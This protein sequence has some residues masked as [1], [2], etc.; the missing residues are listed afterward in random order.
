MFT[1]FLNNHAGII[2]DLMSLYDVLPITDVHYCKIEANPVRDIDITFICVNETRIEE[3]IQ[4]LICAKVK[5][6][7][8]IKSTTPPNTTSSLMHKYGSHICHNPEFLRQAHAFEDIL[9]PDRVIIGECCKKHGVELE[10][11]YDDIYAKKIPIIRT[12]PTSS[13]IAKLVANNYLS[14]LITYW[15]EIHWLCD[16]LGVNTKHVSDMVLLDKRMSPWRPVIFGKPFDGF[17][18]PK[19]LDQLIQA[20]YN[21]DENPILFE[22]IKVLNKRKR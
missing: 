17:C 19:D 8:V 14:M 1:V 6:L 4:T 21:A 10:A 16:K 13:E 9:S 12:T 20:Y 5:G 15:N 3:A 18:L 11:F 7:Y 22:V 2:A